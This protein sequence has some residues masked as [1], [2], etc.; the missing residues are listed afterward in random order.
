MATRITGMISGLD[1][2]SIIQSLVAAKRTK[3]DDKV[4]EKKK[5]EWK[6]EK[7][8]DINSKLK[9]LM[10]TASNMRMSSD[11]A[12]KTT[13]TTN[14]TA[15]SVITGDK[16]VLG[17]Q[18]LKITQL[19]KTGY[20]TGG[21]IGK[22][23]T[24]LSTL[25]DVSG[26]GSSVGTGSFTIKAGGKKINVELGGA[27]TIS[28]ALNQFKK[29]GLN[30]NF[31]AEQQRLFISSAKSGEANDFEIVA[32]DANGQ[33]ILSTLGLST[34]DSYKTDAE[35]AF[36]PAA[37]LA[38]YSS[39]ITA[40]VA[41]QTK[42]ILD[43]YKENH[44]TYAT[45]LEE[46]TALYEA[47]IAK[48]EHLEELQARKDKLAEIA[49]KQEAGEELSDEEND[50][51]AA[52]APL[53][54]DEEAELT[55][56]LSDDETELIK[57]YQDYVAKEE[58]YQGKISLVDNGDGTFT[59]Q[60][61]A[62]Y[63]ASLT[64][65][66]ENT[67]LKNAQA[68]YNG[69]KGL[70]DAQRLA[71]KVNGQDAVI[72]LNDAKFTSTSNVFEINGL[73]LTTNALTAPGEEITITT[74]NDTSAMYEMIKKFIKEYSDLVNEMDSLYNA[75]SAKGFEPLT[76]EE[77][78]SMTESEIEEWETKIKDALFRR[79]GNLSEINNS[80]QD[81]MLQGFK[82]G[83]KTM[84]LSDFGI[85]TLSFFE[86]S[87][88]EKH[89]YHIDGDEE[90]EKTSSKPNILKNMIES[91]PDTVVK[92]FQQLSNSLYQKMYSM[93]GTSAYSSFGSFYDDKEMTKTYKGFD[94]EI[95]TLEDKLADYEDKWYKKFSKME[96]A[97][98]KMQSS[99]SALTGIFGGNQQQ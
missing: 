30:A 54:E 47:A 63:E 96:T 27:S 92:F 55:A 51:L 20:L 48:R 11:Y 28:D 61:D 21:K 44:S 6:Q 1:T 64:A 80:L 7:W 36:D 5:M 50:Y 66:A 2:E 72:Y 74:E 12:K 14:N 32:N 67:V 9:G 24:A 62:D 89:A 86:S 43:D 41:A 76:N 25:N 15:V 38:M 31:D 53:T 40:D 35:G 93:S 56:G 68:Q 4:K 8:K 49:A 69:R 52:N 60:I 16:A 84:Y 23:L 98:S 99:A 34:Q 95:K 78:E 18:S 39:K 29:A 79:D 10:T 22:N 19:A 45:F 70:D 26:S 73:T 90:D 59:P 91:D 97:L 33:Q 94:G 13:K 58:N 42:A 3:V 46:N 81:I 65:K 77:K 83:N 85:N 57:T 71:T 17:T 37:T 75:T 87:D 82:V 88:N